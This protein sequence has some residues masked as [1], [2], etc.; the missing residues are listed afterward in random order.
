MNS[1]ERWRAILERKPV[2][3]IPCDLWATN[4]VFEMLCKE[5]DCNDR[6]EVF[7]KLRIDAPYEVQPQ[8]IGPEL[9]DGSDIWGVKYRK[10][11]Y[12]MGSYNEAVFHPLAEVGTVED[13]KNHQ[14]PSADW[15]D[16][17]RIK[18]N[19]EKHPHRPIRAG[20]I[21]PFLF[22]SY[23]R[24]MEQAM[25]DMVENAELI[26]CAFD[27]MFDFATR[28]FER[29]LDA[30]DG[31][32]DIT[33]PAE[34]LGSQIG[35]L[36]SLECFR[37]FHKGRF[38]KYMEF[39]H[40][41]GVFVF[42]HTDGAARDFIPELIEIGVDILNP[43]QWRCPGMAREGLKKDFG[44]H[45]V[46]HGGV[47]NQQTLPFGRPQDVR[48]EVI[49]CF[50][51]LGAGGGYI[52]APCHNIQPNTPI[53]NILEMYETIREISSDPKYTRGNLQQ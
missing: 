9:S 32:V 44:E 24:G 22:Y 14:W 10:V 34:D 21:E 7:D 2:D 5:L 45:L 19:I 12:G 35:P 15:F 39:A 49:E 20:Y 41:A 13:I 50:E 42:Y 4:E 18:E 17:S 8:Y 40:Q 28:Q 53:E 6:W 43:I 37:R 27:Y 48:E 16:Y 31:K 26:E 52:C 51:T 47:D 46:F 36:F 3:N 33:V 29:I 1:R 11:D 25:M 38:K 23:M 30:T